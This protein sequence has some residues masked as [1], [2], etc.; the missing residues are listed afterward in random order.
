MDRLVIKD[1][2]TTGGALASG[3]TLWL[4]SFNMAARSAVKPT[5]TSQV[6]ENRLC[7][8]SE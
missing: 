2:I 5:M 4:G 1:S 7:I 3:Q 6:I 8:D